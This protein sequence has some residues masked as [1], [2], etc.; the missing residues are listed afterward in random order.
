MTRTVDYMLT[1]FYT[2]SVHILCIHVF[3]CCRAKHPVKVHVWGGISVRGRTKLCIFEGKMDAIMDIDILRRSLQ[4][5]IEEV[6]PDGH[7]F[8]QD[9]DLKHTSRLAN[10]FFT[11]HNI[12][13]WKTPP[14]SPD[15]NPIENLWHEMKE[16]LR[17]EIKP[18]T[19]QELIT[20]VLGNC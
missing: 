4:P 8:M 13:W 15:C 12:N 11:T 16:Y 9:N 7:R 18:R 1:S 3:F 5:F 17:R 19:K 20:R 2:Y 14:E 6:Y 10:G